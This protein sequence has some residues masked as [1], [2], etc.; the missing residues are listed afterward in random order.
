VDEKVEKQT[1]KQLQ[2]SANLCLHYQFCL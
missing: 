2:I 1:D